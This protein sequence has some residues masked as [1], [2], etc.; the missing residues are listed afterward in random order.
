MPDPPDWVVLSSETANA[1]PT[2]LLKIAGQLTVTPWDALREGMFLI[3]NGRDSF[4]APALSGRRHRF[5]PGCMEACDDRSATVAAQ[6]AARASD[7]YE[8]HW[9][10]PGQVLLI[11][12]R[13]TLHARAAVVPG[14]ANRQL[15]RIAYRETDA[16]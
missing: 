10:V 4:Y 12:N 9:T 6:I 15:I 5:D 2:K 1:T 8:H 13:E 16:R 3:K 7:A 11:D 14:D